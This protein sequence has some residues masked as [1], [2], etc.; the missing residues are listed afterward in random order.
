MF[1]LLSSAASMH[2]HEFSTPPQRNPASKR[3]SLPRTAFPKP[4]PRRNTTYE[5]NITPLY[6]SPARPLSEYIP[7]ASEPVVRFQEPEPDAMNEDARS[8]ANSEESSG[9]IEGRKRRRRIRSTTTY[10]LAHP[11]PTLT[12]KQRLL[13]IRPKLLLQLQ[14]LSAD[15]RPKPVID[16]VPSALVVPRLMKKFPRIFRGKGELGMND[17]MVLKSE[18]YDTP[19]HCNPEETDSDEEGLINRDLVA[20]ICQLR[21][22]CGG[23]SGKAEVVLNDGSVWTAT[24]LPNNLYE[25]V[26][27]DERGDEATARWV[28]RNTVRKSMDLSDGQGYNSN[29]FKFTFSIIDPNSRRHPIM[30]TLT[31]NKLDIPD[32]YTSV[33]SSAAKS[34]PTSH[35]RFFPGEKDDVPQD[36]ELGPDRSTHLIDDNLK[37]LIQVTGIWVALRQGWSPYFKYNDTMISNSATTNP[38]VASNGRV[39]SM[40]LTPDDCRSSPTAIY[41]S[42]PESNS[43]SLGA[44]VGGR[45]RRTC[46]RASPASGNF[47]QVE[48][49]VTT[50]KRSISTGTAFMQR[51]AARRGAGIT[52]SALASDG[53][54][55]CEFSPPRRAVTE[56]S[57]SKPTFPT[58]PASLPPSDLSAAIPETPTRPQRRV[59]SA[60]VPTSMLQ[61]GFTNPSGDR[62]S[63]DITG[64]PLDLTPKP[65]IGRWKTFT[66]LFRRTNSNARLQ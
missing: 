58:M 47:S 11:A 29:D 7:R 3:N 51:A 53:E 48:S 30:A 57:I 49:A 28:K 59:Q 27:V 35:I 39:R 33:S 1:T 55:E 66:N 10:T 2:G 26:T 6:T 4:L 8:L 19:D 18:E 37:I 20:V 50:P 38:R 32:S 34:P 44:L 25:F 15:S 63:L 61:H 45:I 9:T 64:R 42:T 16:V 60:Y 52:T 54:G 65:K 31:Q 24:P 43:S 14:R 41:S 22:D 56:A 46:A 12:K 17:V 5:S 36:S 40:S 21:K 13:H 62:H 23:S